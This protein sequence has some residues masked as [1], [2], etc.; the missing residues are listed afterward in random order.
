MWNITTEKDW[1]VYCQSIKF[2]VISKDHYLNNLFVK[3]MDEISCI[4][5]LHRHFRHCLMKSSMTQLGLTTHFS[6]IY[7]LPGKYNAFLV[8]LCLRC[9][10][11]SLFTVETIQGDRIRFR[12]INQI[13]RMIISVISYY[14][15]TNWYSVIAILG[16]QWF[17]NEEGFSFFISNRSWHYNLRQL[18]LITIG[19]DFTKTMACFEKF[20]TAKT[21]E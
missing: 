17:H 20:V 8:S 11:R 6:S 9:H 4:A 21:A 5:F 13:R 12:A 18:R 10:H 16:I 19:W 3:T 7:L 1:S 2:S 15:K 14:Q